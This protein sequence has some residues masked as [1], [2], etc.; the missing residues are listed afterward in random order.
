MHMC[1]D[2]GGCGNQRP[3]LL[4][5][6]PLS[7][8]LREGFSPNLEFTDWLGMLSYWALPPPHNAEVRGAYSHSQLCMCVLEIWNQALMLGLQTFSKH[9]IVL[10]VWNRSW[11]FF[12]NYVWNSSDWIFLMASLVF[13]RKYGFW[14]HLVSVSYPAV[15]SLHMPSCLTTS[16]IYVYFSLSCVTCCVDGLAVPHDYLLEYSAINSPPMRTFPSCIFLLF[17]SPMLFFWHESYL[18]AMILLN[19]LYLCWF[20]VSA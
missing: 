11:I 1:V 12:V 10:Q 4:G 19:C 7:L 5:C 13:R 20:S 15:L 9:L 6:L 18:S 8:S 14:G 3:I 17:K 16:R 2:A